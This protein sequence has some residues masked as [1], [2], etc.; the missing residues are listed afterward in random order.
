MTNPLD[1]SRPAVTVVGLGAMGA[2]L[3]RTL[4]EVGTRLTV[5][6]RTPAR[7]GA[8]VEAGAHYFD[9]LGTAVAHADLVVI[10]VRDHPAARQVLAAAAPH[11]KAGA[12]VV[13]LS[14]ASARDARQTATIA[15]Q[16]RLS[17]LSGAIMVPTPMIGSPDAL[18]LY[19]G[20]PEVF[21]RR[22]ELLRRLAGNAVLVGPDHGQAAVLDLAMLDMYFAG[23]TS[24]LHAAALVAAEGVSARTFL[25][26]AEEV[27][28][29]LRATLAGLA[30]DVDAGTYPGTEDTLAMERDFLAH[31]VQSSEEA[32]VDPALPALS[33]AYAER[34][35]AAGHG[36]DGYSRLVDL[37]SSKRTPAA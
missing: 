8:L 14:S 5:W 10:C 9:D 23:M 7:A 6:N 2:S 28:G 25:P 21:E 18:I 15:A 19:S 1:R 32:G 27:V 36:G 37:L 33:L 20:P 17:Y 30:G 35:V 11:L 26:Y 3:A 29:T 16:L 13:N 12:D 4:L 31:I 34:A 24:F 22:A